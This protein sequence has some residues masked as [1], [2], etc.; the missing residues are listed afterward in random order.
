MLGYWNRPAADQVI[1]IEG[2]FRT[3]DLVTRSSSGMLRI[4]GRLKDMI[5]RAGENVAAAEVEAVLVQHPDVVAVAVVSVPDATRGEEVKAFVQCGEHRPTPAAL[6]A[7]AAERL[8][9][10]KVPRYFE[11]VD[12]L[13]MTASA[14]VA[15]HQLIHG[16]AWD[17]TA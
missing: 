7:F 1:D 15:K 5:R 16:V 3:G 17:A 10:F 11:L 6:H 13:P 9:V 8:A 2:W 12:S 4:T 14:R